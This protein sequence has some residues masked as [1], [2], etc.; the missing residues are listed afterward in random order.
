MTG[1]NPVLATNNNNIN[2]NKGNTNM[3][4]K[5]FDSRYNTRDC[6]GIIIKASVI[7][8][9]G[10]VVFNGTTREVDD[11]MDLDCSPIWKDN[12]YIGQQ[13]NGKRVIN[14]NLSEKYAENIF[15]QLNF[16]L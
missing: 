8:F 9:D 6:N 10:N 1:S 4:Y 2:L 5:N 11:F 14:T 16:S 12:K 13:Y 3:N 7:D 15:N